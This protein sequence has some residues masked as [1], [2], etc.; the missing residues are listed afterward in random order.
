MDNIKDQKENLLKAVQALPSD[1]LADL[2]EYY[3]TSES[4]ES[5]ARRLY[6]DAKE[7]AEGAKDIAD[8]KCY[9]YGEVGYYIEEDA[10]E[11]QEECAELYKPFK[12][13]AHAYFD[14]ITDLANS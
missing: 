2:C 10:K 4:A 9:G 6:A 14:I 13:L 3:S 5:L 8:R 1:K 7:S 12:R 11:V